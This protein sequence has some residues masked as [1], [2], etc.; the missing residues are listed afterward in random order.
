[1]GSASFKS[2]VANLQRLGLAQTLDLHMLE[3]QPWQLSLVKAPVRANRSDVQYQPP[4]L[5]P[6]RD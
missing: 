2:Y 6:P 5:L 1:M 3:N 4:K